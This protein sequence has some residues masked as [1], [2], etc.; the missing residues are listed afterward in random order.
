MLIMWSGS[1]STVIHE[2]NMSQTSSSKSKR[3]I[4]H[5]GDGEPVNMP[6]KQPIMIWR[7]RQCI[8][9]SQ[10]VAS[11]QRKS[12]SK[13]PSSI[14]KLFKWILFFGGVTFLFIGQFFSDTILCM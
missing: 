4:K 14:E 11:T 5:K 9:R 12:N 7:G 3:R 2:G 8:E 1:T 13:V 10:L 6:Y